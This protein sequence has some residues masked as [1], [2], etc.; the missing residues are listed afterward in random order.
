MRSEDDCK[1]GCLLIE[2]ED[3]G[4]GNIAGLI[5]QLEGIEAAGEVAEV[6]GV[7]VHHVGNIF[8]H[9]AQ[10]AENLQSIGH[11]G[12]LLKLKYDVGNG[13]VGIELLDHFMLRIG[14]RTP[15]LASGLGSC[16]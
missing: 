1:P 15:C 7:V 9:F 14:H 13:G 10:K 6:D 11:I 2:L 3:A 5:A 4:V 16:Q 8:D 12:L